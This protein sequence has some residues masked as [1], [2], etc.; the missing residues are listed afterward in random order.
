MNYPPRSLA[1]AF[2]TAVLT[3]ALAWG[4]AAPAAP[5]QAGTESKS[6]DKAA[7]YYDFAMGHLY[8]ELAGAFG[9]RSDYTNKAIEYYRQAMKLDPSASFLAEELTDLYIQAGRIKDAVSEAEDLIK[10]NPDN[11][12]ARR[13]LGR[14]YARL[15]GDPQQNRINEEML[16]RS[17]EQFQKV[18]EKDPKDIESWLML[19][20]LERVAHNSVDAEKAYKKVL[21]QDA[22]NEEALTGLAMV[23]SEVGDTRNAIEMLRLVTSKNPNPRTLSALATF[24]EQNRDYANAADAWKQAL[25][26]DPENGRIKRAL[27][28]DVLFTDHFD[29]ALKLYNEIA[30]SD[31]RD[32]QV[33]LR[34]SEIYRQKG[35]FAKARAAF[36]K[37][38]DLDHDSLEVRYEEVSLLEAEGKTDDAIAAL[39]NIL[40]DTAK[41]SYSD[42][43]RSSRT[44]LLERLGMIYRNANRTSEAVDA[45]RQIAQVD[46]NA[47]PRASVEVI[48]TYS[49]AKDFAK[50]Q[51]EA[52]AAL[53]KFPKERMVKLAHASLLADQGKFDDAIAELKGLLNGEKDRETQLAIAQI[54]ERGKRFD[55]M[56]KALD[57]A[58][59][60]S[61]NNQD[62]QAVLFMRGAMY[63]RMKKFD[64][65]EAEFRKVLAIDP[66][67]AG[68]LNY[69]GYML[70]DRNVRLDE[71]QKM[72]SK[73]VQLDPTN[74]AY[75]DSLGWVYYRQNR[76]EEAAGYLERALQKIAKD[77]TVHDHLGDVY[78]KQGKIREAI[79]QWQNSL[80]DYEAG[81]QTDID[82]G[83]MATV[84]KKLEDA[85]VRVAKEGTV[86]KDKQR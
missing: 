73:A 24:Y 67:N 76:L 7:A 74:G 3:S 60:L 47:A 81:T 75:L 33:Q 66:D 9:N 13:L 46:P 10:Q 59:K 51:E 6:N 25:Q 63:E 1:A 62:K 64:E 44:M 14:V 4:Q 65:A 70:A 56:A 39:K 53:K 84:S 8:S 77:P 21:D 54:S 27:A 26:M 69:L 52:Q 80:K 86:D 58:E 23:Y 19:G 82:P 16:K 40:A 32:A 36:T 37:A 11:L 12:D 35:D 17:I 68:A 31:P 28:Q 15:I 29:E 34:I 30:A 57:G 22:S 72:V 83:E 78:F 50:A 2:C 20:R 43:E 41:K 5:S 48:N 55:E 61:D 42:S 45:F 18:T 85:R 49:G 71:A 38:K 79:V